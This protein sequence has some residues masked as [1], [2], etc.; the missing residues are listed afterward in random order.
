MTTPPVATAPLV[1]EADECVIAGPEVGAG[2]EAGQSRGRRWL[3]GL[4]CCITY[5]VLAV[6]MF[7]HVGDLG[8]AHLS[9]I[10]SSDNVVQIWWLEWAQYALWHGQNL[11]YTNWQNFPAGQNFGDNSSM[12]ALGVLFSPITRLFGP[13][14]AWNVLVRVGVVASAASMCF[15][16]RR[17]TSWWP[18]AFVGGLLYGFSA[19]AAYYGGYLF[20]MFVPLPP[21]FFLLLHEVF[22]RQQWPPVRTGL[23][24]AAVVVVQY[25]V[26]T[27]VT[28]SMVLLGALAVL[29]VVI[30]RRR[31]LLAAG[32]HYAAKALGWAVGATA[33]VLFVPV[34]Y[35]FTGPEHVTGA[36]FAPYYLSLLNPDLLSALAPVNE[37]IHPSLI[38]IK[39]ASLVYGGLLYLGLPLVVVVAGFAI[40]FRKRR[41]ILLAGVLAATSFVL[42][43]GSHLIIDGHS[44]SVL[45]PFRLFLHLPLLNGLLSS[46]FALYTALFTAAMFA[47][48]LDELWLR[49]SGSGRWQRASAGGRVLRAGVVVVL[50]AVV[51]L[52]LVPASTQSV[53]PA[54]PPPF[55]TSAA[56]G[57][58]RPGSVVLAYPYPDPAA[59]NGYSIL[60][61]VRP[62]LLDQAVARMRFKL[63]GGYGWFPSPYGVDGTTQPKVLHPSVVEQLFDAA[64]SGTPSPDVQRAE[65]SGQLTA[66]LRQFLRFYHV[67]TVVVVPVHD[68]TQVSRAVDAAIGPGTVTGGVT[69][70][71]HVQQRLGSASVLAAVHG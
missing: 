10:G 16:L 62:L 49:M 54:A 15:V 59:T 3:P 36:P 7:G 13:V 64:Y 24:L 57:V 17:C 47:V 38:P 48:G 63:I 50:V 5:A 42:S 33:V 26:S 35:T 4:V 60:V 44:T 58:I 9:G 25:F 70:W 69:V 20:L 53:S 21:L 22:V 71:P 19:Y 8:S 34:A 43:L 68:W 45:M 39:G 32:W 11:L 12:L 29:I 23:A 37:W 51:V 41:A 40:A 18:A 6:L 28:A 46:R 55:F 14:V 66:D 52:P 56:A 30:A 1:D 2:Q 31:P 61:P 65:A 27:E 67:G